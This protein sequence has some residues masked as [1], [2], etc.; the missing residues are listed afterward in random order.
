MQFESDEEVR[1]YMLVVC[2]QIVFFGSR[3]DIKCAFC[4]P[5]GR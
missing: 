5:A 1:F 2:G 4:S 3:C